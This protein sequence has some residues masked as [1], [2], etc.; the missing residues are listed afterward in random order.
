[1][2][3]NELRLHENPK[4]LLKHTAS[5][6]NE[7]SNN[8]KTYIFHKKSSD[9]AYWWIFMKLVTLNRKSSTVSIVNGTIN[10]QI[11]VFLQ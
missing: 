6:Q 4:V 5:C 10:L 2:H 1:M 3:L 7:P 8:V 11:M 9:F